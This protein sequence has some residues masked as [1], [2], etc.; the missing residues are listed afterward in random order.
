MQIMANKAVVFELCIK[1]PE[2]KTWSG[3]KG[4][5]TFYHHG[6]CCFQIVLQYISHNFKELDLN[7]NKVY[8]H[9]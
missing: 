8:S 5:L 7:F 9:Q 2:Q 1:T 3:K 6:V 4:L